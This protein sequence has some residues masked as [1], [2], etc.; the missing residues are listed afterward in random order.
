[1]T[2]LNNELA[3]RQTLIEKIQSLEKQLEAEKAN[4]KAMADTMAQYVARKESAE[5]KHSTL[6]ITI[7]TLIMQLPDKYRRPFINSIPN[8]RATK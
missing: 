2:H 3:I 4:Y 7:G 1:M 5:Q 6:I 8:L